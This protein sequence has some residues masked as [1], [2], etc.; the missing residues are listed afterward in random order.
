M[1]MT[2]REIAIASVSNILTSWIGTHDLDVAIPI[3]DQLIMDGI[4]SL[5]YA[6]DPD[7]SAAVDQFQIMFHTTAPL[8][9]DRFAASRLTKR[10]GLAT[11]LFFIQ[12]LGNRRTEKFA[13]V[14]NSLTQLEQ[15]WPSIEKFIGTEGRKEGLDV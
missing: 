8:K 15:K 1:T 12:Q 11:V 4:I 6:G 10:H 9:T 3:V 7:V 14:V 2:K 13:P 5:A